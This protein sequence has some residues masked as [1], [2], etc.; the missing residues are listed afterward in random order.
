MLSYFELAVLRV[1]VPGR[2]VRTDDIMARV[3]VADPWPVWATFPRLAAV[4]V[5]LN[6]RGFVARDYD[7]VT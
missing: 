1:M 6:R 4:L 2:P 5:A 7:P 3:V